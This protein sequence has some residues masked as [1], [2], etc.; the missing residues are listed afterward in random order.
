MSEAGG[1]RTLHFGSDYIQSQMVVGE[2]D[3]LALAYTRTMMSFEMFV[4]RPREIALL[5]LGG[6]SIAK[7]CHRHHAESRI[8]VVEINPQVIAV[9]EAFDVP[10]LSEKF[11]ILCDDAASSWP[12]PQQGSMYC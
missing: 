12:A 5:G 7:W 3:F 10:P 1:V 9:A 11:C 6:G 4:P 2:P 8:T